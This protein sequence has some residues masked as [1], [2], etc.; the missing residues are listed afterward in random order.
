ME[1]LLVS[2]E[3]QPAELQEFI[4][5]FLAHEDFT[6]SQLIKAHSFSPSFFAYT[7]RLSASI[8]KII[9]PLPPSYVATISSP[10]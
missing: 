6:Q 10:S 9:L 4:N 1:S 8:N 3:S 7:F 5:Y 2:L